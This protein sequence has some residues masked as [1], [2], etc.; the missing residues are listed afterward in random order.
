MALGY[1]PAVMSAH[2]RSF[3]WPRW[4]V[5]LL[6]LGVIGAAGPGCTGKGA[7]TARTYTVRGQVVQLPDP[8]NPGSGLSLNHEAVDDFVDRTGEVVGMDPMSM[9]FP[10]AK[11]LSLEG[12]QVGDV[13]EFKLS[14][15]WEG[16][17]AVEVTG[18][19]KLPAGTKLVFRA[20]KPPTK[21]K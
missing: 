11:N 13:V 10:T 15:D 21:S 1:D 18:V 12:I 16:D 6:I 4:T 17:P 5:L 14:V 3:R 2:V 8:G 19:R 20:A 7:G 9:P